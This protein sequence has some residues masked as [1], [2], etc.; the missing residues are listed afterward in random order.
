MQLPSQQH[1]GGERTVNL[2]CADSWCRAFSVMTALSK[3]V[4]LV[5]VMALRDADKHCVSPLIWTRAFSLEEVCNSLH[6]SSSTLQFGLLE[7]LDNRI[8]CLVDL[9]K[10]FTSAGL[11]EL[12]CLHN[13][14]TSVSTDAV[15]CIL[16]P[17]VDSHNTLH[18]LCSKSSS[19]WVSVGNAV[20]C[21]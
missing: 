7:M 8:I 14:N 20:G 16:G 12:C 11:N 2:V 3:Q 17:S 21:I 19:H 6:C 15:K 13:E 1:L 5:A 4:H 9:P 18:F 10:L